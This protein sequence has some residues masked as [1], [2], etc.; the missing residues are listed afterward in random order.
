[1]P[2]PY[3]WASLLESVG[4]KE[5]KSGKLYRDYFLQFL[6]MTENLQT[7]ILMLPLQLDSPLLALI[8]RYVAFDGFEH[9]HLVVF[10]RFFH[11]VNLQRLSLFSNSENQTNLFLI[12]LLVF[13]H[14]WLLLLVFGFVFAISIPISSSK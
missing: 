12:F 2:V 3:L 8:G 1:M 11:R 7:S 5:K 10:L 14:K 13:G 9:T 4:K 6:S